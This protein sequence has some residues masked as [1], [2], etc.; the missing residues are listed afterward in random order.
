[1]I[2]KNFIRNL[3]YKVTGACIEV[4]KNLGQGL[5]E[6]LYHKCL[7]KEFELSRIN[8]FSEKSINIFYKGVSVDTKLR[9]DFIIEDCLIIEIK[10]VEKVLPI[11]EAQLLTYMKLLNIPKGLLINFNCTNIIQSGKKSLVNELYRSLAE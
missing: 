9:A 10:S 8:F 7:E 11:H 4:H 5:L 2:N 6:S 1:M 3:E